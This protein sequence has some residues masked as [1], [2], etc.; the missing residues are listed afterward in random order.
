[1]RVYA[2][3]MR[4]GAPASSAATGSSLLGACASQ[5]LYQS[6]GIGRFFASSVPGFSQRSACRAQALSDI[7]LELKM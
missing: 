5:P 3:A 2:M 6:S 4:T 1:M 7:S